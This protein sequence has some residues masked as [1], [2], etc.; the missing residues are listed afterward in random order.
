MFL[1]P[2]QETREHVPSYY[3]A[4]LGEH[5]SY[6]TLAD[7]I[8]TDVCVIGGGFS[9]ISTALHLAERGYRV[10]VIEGN[11]IGWGATGRNGGQLIGGFSM[12]ADDLRKDLGAE[13]ARKVWQ[14]GQEGV[15]II[16]ERVATYGI[17]CDLRFGYC[18][19]ALKPRNMADFEADLH[20]QQEL[21]YPHA[22]RLVERDELRTI[23]KSDQYLGGLLNEGYG[24]LHPLKLCLGEAR[25]AAGLGVQ[26]FEQTRA[27]R[28]EHGPRPVVHTEHGR[29]RARY[30]AVC[31]DAYLGS[32]VP[33]LSSRNLPASSFVIATA[34]LG[35]RA[36]SV[37]TR[38]LAVCDTRWALDYF[39]L[40]VDGRLVFGGACNY[41]GLAPA[42]VTETMRQK[43]LKVFPQ[44]HDVAIDY[45]WGGQI[46]ISMNR[47]PQ[48]G[49][50]SENVLYAQGY[51][52][53]GVAPTHLMGKLLAETVAG[54]AE[55]FDLFARYKHMPFPGGKWMRQP[56]YALGML[57]YRTL[58][59]L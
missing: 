58:D 7:S 1:R 36:A 28:L 15:D 51:S 21:G 22:M 38:E 52:G 4:T 33:S 2:L 23:I 30:V 10:V 47:I 13:G 35:E 3:A 8:E 56:L 53:H 44:L 11:R 17:D 32:L 40:S 20:R 26:I 34:P 43:M 19:V 29:V 57:Y 5:A 9:G 46:G 45:T 27:I 31:G 42:N 14:M 16:K 41:T 55:R 54:H 59:L 37:M 25:A 49:R 39:R 48:V 18:D 6:P 12:D 50:L 24:Q